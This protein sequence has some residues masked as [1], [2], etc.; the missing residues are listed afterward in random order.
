MRNNIVKSIALGATLAI[1]A[2]VGSVAQAAVVVITKPAR[3]VSCTYYPSG[4]AVCVSHGVSQKY[5][6]V[7]K[8]VCTPQG[9]CHWEYCYRT[10]PVS[11]VCKSYY[12]NRLY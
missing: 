7:K 6:G 4:Y 5:Y 10:G 1:M 8:R 9:L 2:A 3:A 12:P 11:G